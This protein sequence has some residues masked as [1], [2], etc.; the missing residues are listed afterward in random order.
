[1][2]LDDWEQFLGNKHRTTRTHYSMGRK[3]ERC[4]RFIVNGSKTGYCRVC[5]RI[6]KEN[7]HEDDSISIK[8]GES[9]GHKQIKEL[10]VKWL[11]R[12]KCKDITAER[13]I[14]TPRGSIRA[15]V[16]GRYNGSWIIVECGGSQRQKLEKALL[17]TRNVY[18]W[19]YHQD[20]PYLYNPSMIICHA[21][22]T[23][24]GNVNNGT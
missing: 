6:I 21:C 23:F 7:G 1:M 22:G 8:G 16:A 20:K 18:I 12:I 17:F 15:D 5:W 4:G 3:C 9:E 11:L 2:S 10:A 13:N 19:A 24:K 14:K